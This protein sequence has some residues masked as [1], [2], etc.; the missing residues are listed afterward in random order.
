MTV[1]VAAVLRQWCKVCQAATL[2][3][4][5]EVCPGDC[6]VCAVCGSGC[7]GQLTFDE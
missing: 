7:T 4:P 5:C 6:I 1:L 3:K 2:S